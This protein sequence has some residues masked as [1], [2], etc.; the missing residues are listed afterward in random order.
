VRV[1][2]DNDMS[3]ENE[4]PPDAE[5]F[6][7]EQERMIRDH[8]ERPQRLDRICREAEVLWRAAHPWTSDPTLRA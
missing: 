8:A 3:E 6:Q 1:I 2:P 7:R 4:D 5:A